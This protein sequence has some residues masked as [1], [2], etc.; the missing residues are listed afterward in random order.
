MIPAREQVDLDAPH[1]PA[2]DLERPNR[3]LH[4]FLDEQRIKYLDL[5]PAFRQAARPGQLYWPWNAHFNVAGNRLASL[6]VA[7]Y[8][9]DSGLLH[10]EGSPEKRQSVERE[11]RA[12]HASN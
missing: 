12:L 1:A 10:V 2:I 3:V 8:L 5:L 11:L 4:A 9:L 6:L 7:R